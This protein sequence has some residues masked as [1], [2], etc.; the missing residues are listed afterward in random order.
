MHNLLGRREGAVTPEVWSEDW[1]S[2]DG[3]AGHVPG[4]NYLLDV[5][6]MDLRKREPQKKREQQKIGARVTE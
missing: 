2:R 1:T 4:N 3:Y 6:R 5:A